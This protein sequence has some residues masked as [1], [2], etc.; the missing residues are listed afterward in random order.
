M[1][2]NEITKCFGTL[3]ANDCISLEVQRGEVLAL[4]GENGAGK[5]TLMNILFGHYVADSGSAEVFGKILPPGSPRSALASAIGMVHQH[6]NL[7]DNLSVIENVM[8]GTEPLL[9]VRTKHAEA[10]R[11]LAEL[12]ERFGLLLN[13]DAIVGT[14]SVGERQRVE[15]LKTLYRK[16]QILIL[17]E[18]TAVLTP[19]E[20]ESLF[21]TL[22]RLNQEGLSIVFISHKLDEVM[23]V[24]DRVVVLRAGRVVAERE[25]GSTTRNELAELMVGRE[26]PQPLRKPQ[27]AGDSV[28]ELREVSVREGSKPL[29]DG[30]NLIVRESEII[31][32]AGVSGNGQKV[33]A[34]L[35]S[36]LLCPNDGQLRLFGAD[37]TTPRPRNF[38]RAGV[39]RIPEDRHASGIMTDM[40]IWENMISE[41][42]RDEFSTWGLI[43]R[44]K[45]INETKKIIHDFDIH[46]EGPMALIGQLS[47]GNIQKLILGRA[48]ALQPKLIVAI[49][50]TRGLDVGAVAYVHNQ[51]LEARRQGVGVLLI[52]EDL[53]ELLALC[54]RIGVMYQGK[55]TPTKITE[56]LS[57]QEIGM[58]MAG[59]WQ[60]KGY[61]V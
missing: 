53:D 55:L 50:P 39:A 6:F 18:P 49:Q 31:G 48:L 47:G 30:I 60:E 3:R 42:Y 24:S 13:P 56:S 27:K 43:R 9:A 7:A 54:D 2:L 21:S 11:R 37:V 52:S 44:G 26:V 40:A 4:L 5:T 14:L 32:I 1:R 51:L 15:I 33:L 10:R 35:G 25:T 16:A 45:A 19:Q 8:I 23:R 38:V 57:I 12:T 20:T 61:A 58:L 28:F 17:D 41:R 29:L 59:Q 22:G 46:C 34:D 36:G